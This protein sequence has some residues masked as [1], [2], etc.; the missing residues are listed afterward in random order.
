M[1]VHKN[2]RTTMRSRA[3]LVRRM[4]EESQAPKAVATAFGVDVKTVKKWVARFVAEGL[5]GLADRSSRPHRLNKPTPDE[6]CARIL[7]LRRRRWTGEQIANETGVSPATVSRVLGRAGLSRIKDLEPAE[8]PVRYEYETWGAHPH[9]H[10]E[11]WP[12]RQ[13]RPP[14]HRQAHRH[15]QLAGQRLG[16]RPRLHR[17]QLPRRLQP[18]PARRE[19]G[20]RHRLPDGGLGLLR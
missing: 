5:A 18:D 9:R 12:L 19:E 13:N 16:V 3:E 17:R 2:A 10:Q 15:R 4:L 7:E 14:H 20:E 11:A 6:V 1:N 8:P